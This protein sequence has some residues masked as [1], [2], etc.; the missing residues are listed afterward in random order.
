MHSQFSAEF[1]N[2]PESDEAQAI[3]RRCV[4]CGFCNAT[5]PTYQLK[6]DELDG[7]RGRIYLI[8]QMLEGNAVTQRT[9]HHID[10]CLSCRSCETTCPSGVEYGRL[11]DIGRHLVDQKVPRPFVQKLIRRTLL[12]WLPYQHRF[13]RL[14]RAARRIRPFLPTHLKYKIPVSQPT[15]EWPEARHPRK[16][17]LLDG[18]VQQT[19][20]PNINASSAYVLNQL[21]ISAIRQPDAGCCGALNYHLS[22]QAGGLDFMR[23]LIDSCWPHIESG[24]EAILMTA[25]GCGAMLKDYR[26]LL[27][28]DP[29][30]AEKAERFSSLCKDLSEV[31]VNEDLSLLRIRSRNIAFQSPCSLQH[32]QKLNGAVETLLTKLGFSL[33]PVD[34]AHFCCGS[35][36]TYSI[37]Q[38]E[39]ANQLR[40]RKLGHLLKHQPE[41]IA[42]AN[43]GCL[44]H[45]QEKSDVPVI[46]WIELLS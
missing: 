8:K 24:V 21:G 11:A 23:Q 44:L 34:E 27:G 29:V 25:S 38:A 31:L 45:L 22:D 17:L 42:T 1:D 14:M 4:H 39:I 12:W 16:V 6:G 9:Q 20:A 33:M 18:C 19:L 40:T 26:H 7:P 36:G 5:C 32:G 10:R 13:S 43:I 35:A 2:N 37:M 46:H 41:V 30:Y 15:I 3:L 28:N